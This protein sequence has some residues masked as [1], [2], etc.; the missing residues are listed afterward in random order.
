M[1]INEV[2]IRLLK[3]KLDVEI[4]TAIANIMSSILVDPDIND[5]DAYKSGAYL[6]FNKREFLKS[7]ESTCNKFTK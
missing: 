5:V 4:N 2:L 7:I 1:F 6:E 3:D